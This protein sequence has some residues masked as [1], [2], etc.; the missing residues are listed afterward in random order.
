MTVCLLLRHGGH[1]L[2]D[3]EDYE[4]VAAEGAWAAYQRED[5]KCYARS[6]RRGWILLHRFIMETPKGMVTDHLNGDTMDN[7]RANLRVCSSMEN[8][9]NRKLCSGNKTGVAGVDVF[10]G[11]YRAQINTPERRIYLG[12]FETLAEAVAARKAAELVLYSKQDRARAHLR[13]GAAA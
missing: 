11:K 2:I 8:N 10:R 5:G 13:Y 6:T 4:R 7:R 1:V 12:S 9:R 3:A